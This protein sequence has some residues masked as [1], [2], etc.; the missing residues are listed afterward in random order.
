MKKYVFIVILVI[1][2]GISFGENIDNSWITSEN[3]IQSEET[4]TVTQ[5]L[6]LAEMTNTSLDNIHARFCSSSEDTLKTWLDLQIRPWQRKEICVVFFNRWDKP[7]DI[8]FWFAEW[9]VNKDGSP[10]CDWDITNSN[11]FS[12][13]ITHNQE[14]GFTLPAQKSIIKKIIYAAPKYVS[15]NILWCL[16]YKLSKEEKVNMGVFLM[17]TRKVGYM[18]IAVTWSV[19]NFWRRDDIKDVY[20]ANRTGILKIIIG[21]LAVWIIV[22]IIQ[23][24]KKKEKSHHKKK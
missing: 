24:T 13:F 16:A 12:K 23:P 17:T 10:V 2:C 11:D 6:D 15:G 22:T 18:T 3:I 20:I 9:S 8:S 7:I 21:V 14:T 1:S 4:K 19:Y 5:N